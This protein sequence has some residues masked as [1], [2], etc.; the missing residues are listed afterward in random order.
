MFC[1]YDEK[2]ELIAF[3][4]YV[5]VVESYVNHIKAHHKDAEL[6]IGKIKRKK[7]KERLYDL[8]LVRYAET[9][10]QQGY[11]DYLSFY[12]DQGIYDIKYAKEVLIRLLGGG[13]YEGKEK[14]NLEKTILL[15][16]KELEDEE[17]YTP[18]LSQLKRLKMNYESYQYNMG[19]Y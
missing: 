10:V 8:Y 7:I 11:L 12:S 15:L 2:G 14:K 18:T 1:V 4:D 17:N 5:D 19:C 9:Y 3:H 6:H 16:D 13:V